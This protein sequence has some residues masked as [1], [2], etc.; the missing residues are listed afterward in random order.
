MVEVRDLTKYYSDVRIINRLYFT[1]PQNSVSGIIG[2]NGAGKS[3]LIKIISGFENQTSGDVL[4]NNKIVNDF[5]D[6]KKYISYMPEFMLLYP[7]YFVKEFLD[8]FHKQINYKDD[9]LMDFLGLKSVFDKKISH[10]SKGWHQRLKLY[11]SLAMNRDIIILDEPF[12]GFDPLQMNDILKIFDLKKD[13]TFILSIHQLSQAQKIC[14]YFVLLDNGN[15]ISYG[16]I[17]EL[18]EKFNCS[19]D[20]LEDIFIKALKKDG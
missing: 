7:D 11:T 20:L 8:F 4:I 18:K 5:D 3:T 2:P 6:K 17:E 9:E 12:D 19:S 14:D 15:L 1:I 16:S 13:K 10:L